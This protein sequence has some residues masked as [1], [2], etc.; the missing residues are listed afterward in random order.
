M[1]TLRKF[2]TNGASD[3]SPNSSIKAGKSEAGYG[4][5]ESAADKENGY[6]WPSQK[7]T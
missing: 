3:I 6:L 7:A 4:G 1:K 2:L 5:E